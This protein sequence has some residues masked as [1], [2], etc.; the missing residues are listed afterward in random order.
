MVQKRHQEEISGPCDSIDSAPL[1]ED[2]P[3]PKRELKKSR[4]ARENEAQSQLHWYS[5]RRRPT[6]K[7]QAPPQRGSIQLFYLEQGYQ[8][9]KNK[10]IKAR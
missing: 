6:R 9:V 3:R 10:P 1:A 4:K 7:K 8:S 2:L 5:S